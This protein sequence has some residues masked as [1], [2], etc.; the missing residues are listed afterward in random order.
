[1]KDLSKFE[2]LKTL[3]QEREKKKTNAHDTASLLYNELLEIYY[4][5]YYYLSH[6]KRKKMNRKYKPKKLFI[7]GYDYSMWSKHEEES[8]D[9]ES[10]DEEESTDKEESVDLS[11]MPPLEGDEE[12]KEG[13]G[14]KISTPNKLLNRVPILLA[15]TKLGI[16]H[17]N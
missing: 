12:V 4:D 2:K 3:K 14:I 13:K 8:T 17:T 5:E 9:K 16:I 1:M 7:K 10:T 6:T 11:D 15:Q